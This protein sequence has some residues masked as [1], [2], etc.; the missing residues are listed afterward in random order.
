MT[1][2]QKH[3]VRLVG[4]DSNNEGRLEVLHNNEWG[5]VCDDSFSNIDAEVVCRQLGYRSGQALE[6]APFGQGTGT[7]WL[8]DVAC[9]GTETHIQN[10]SHAGWGIENCDHSEDVGIWCSA[11]IGFLAYSACFECEYDFPDEGGIVVFNGIKYNYGLGYSINSGKFIAP[12]TGLYQITVQVN[13]KS[14][15]AE[16]ALIVD[17]KRM[18]FTDEYDT[19]NENGGT[20]VVGA[21]DIIFQL[22]KGQQLWVEPH[23]KGTFRGFSETW[24]IMSWFGAT[25]LNTNS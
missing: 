7:I 11:Y 4:G 23:F 20:W 8:D 9:E 2:D 3:E 24:G 21:T 19:N 22:D 18:V 12:I 16:H 17:G 1:G 5:S 14:G 15:D 6:K 10:C 13:T 25:L